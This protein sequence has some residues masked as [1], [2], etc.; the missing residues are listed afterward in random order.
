MR[1]EALSIRFSPAAAADAPDLRCTLEAETTAYGANNPTPGD[2][3]NMIARARA[4]QSARTYQQDACPWASWQDETTLVVRLAVIVWPSRPELRYSLHLPAEVAPG[5]VVQYRRQRQWK[6]WAD[7]A[8][9]LL[10]PWRLEGASLAWQAGLPCMDAHCSA[11]PAPDLAHEHAQII[12]AGDVYGVI[13]AHGTAVG[14]RHEF[15]IEVGKLDEDGKPQ[16]IDLDAVPVSVSW[17]DGA[18]DEQEAEINVPIPACAKALLTACP[19][20]RAVYSIRPAGARE[21][22]WEVAYSTCD[23]TVLGKRRVQTGQRRGGAG[24]G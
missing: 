2:L 23:G 12:V 11:I 14:Y 4:G 7:G 8:G 9:T 13:V 20:G 16:V 24:N 15:A 21:D 10:L 22:H 6:Y 19:G 5:E 18:G 3:A 17:T 1:N